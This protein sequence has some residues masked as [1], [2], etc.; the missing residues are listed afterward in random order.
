MKK[1]TNVS[2][3]TA[4]RS[5]IEGAPAPVMDDFTNEEVLAKMDAMIL[6]FKKKGAHS[7]HK[8]TATQEQNEVL[9]GQII[10]ILSDGVLRSTADL[11]IALGLPEDTTPQKITGIIRPAVETGT[12][13]SK[14]VKGKK[15]YFLAD[16][17]G[18]EE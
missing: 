8:K 18:V 13:S 5:M 9:R 11:R 2:V 14:T 17:D 3:L 6:S 7:T 10:D 12:I 15:F 1:L 16:A 4:I